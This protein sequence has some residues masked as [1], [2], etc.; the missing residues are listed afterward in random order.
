[1]SDATDH[2][3]FGVRFG[4]PASLG[5]SVSWGRLNERGPA[6]IGEAIALLCP[7][8]DYSGPLLRRRCAPQSS[9]SSAV[10]AITRSAGTARAKAR[11]CRQADP[12]VGKVFA[13]PRVS[14]AGEDR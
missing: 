2:R 13:A 5:A 12:R 4:C 11:R 9:A 6:A 1:V 8:R 14:S 3:M 10:K 7:D